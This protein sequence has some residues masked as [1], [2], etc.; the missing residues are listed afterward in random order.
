MSITLMSQVWRLD[1]G[2]GDVAR[3]KKLVLMALADHA[4]D[5]GFCFP[6]AAYIGWKTDYSERQCQRL[7]DVLEHDD[8]LI[9][10]AKEHT[11]TTP[12]VYQLTLENAH[13]KKPYER[14]P[15]GRGNIY[16]AVPRGVTDVTPAHENDENG[17]RG[18]TS[19]GQGVTSEH[20]GVTSNAARGDIT[21][22]P[23]SS[24]EPS[25]NH[26]E[27]SKDDLQKD[28]ADVR[29]EIKAVF[30][31]PHDFDWTQVETVFSEISDTRL[32]LQVVH[33]LR[34]TQS[35]ALFDPPAFKRAA[36]FQYAR[37]NAQRGQPHIL[38]MP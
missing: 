2:E 9:R 22:S 18:V 16:T 35:T 6:S 25:K 20:Q 15:S 23:E 29:D 32:L 14:K 27:P 38:R 7:L 12:R 30:T 3:A 34:S 19:N 33:Q 21:V 8:N 26:Q 5:N 31:I 10:V 36:Q 1:L 28:F 11:P 17:A 13:E 4:D 37:Q 24:L